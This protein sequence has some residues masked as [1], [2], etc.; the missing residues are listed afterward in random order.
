MLDQIL[1]FMALPSLFFIAVT[2]QSLLLSSSWRFSILS[3]AGQYMG[4]FILVTINWPIEMAV[5]KVVAGWMACAVLAIGGNEASSAPSVAWVEEDHAWPS[6][7]LFRLLASSLVFLIVISLS[8]RLVE[9]LPHFT[10]AQAAGG[11][12]LIGMGLLHLGLTSQP[13]RVAIGLLTTIA[14]FEILYS[15]VEASALVA[16]LLAT[17]NLGIA[18]AA[19]YLILAPHMEEEQT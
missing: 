5:V 16:G 18:L 1:N 6:S 8:P 11:A 19:V 7:R 4:V 15:V 10:F 13:L 17:V 2:A 14:G 12:V 9:W 3:L